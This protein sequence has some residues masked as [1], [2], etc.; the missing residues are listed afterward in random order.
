MVNKQDRLE[1]AK[2]Y[3]SYGMRKGFIHEEYDF[4]EMSS[5][6]IIDLADQLEAEGERT[7]EAWKEQQ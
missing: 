7:Y 5:Q 2:E 4:D 3:L 6:E 1:A